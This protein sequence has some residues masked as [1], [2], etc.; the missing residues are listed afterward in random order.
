MFKAMVF[1][2]VAGTGA[3]AYFLARSIALVLSA[4]LKGLS[5][6]E[7]TARQF[8]QLICRALNYPFPFLPK[9]SLDPTNIINKALDVILNDVFGN[10][11][12][13][14]SSLNDSNYKQ[15]WTPF[16]RRNLLQ[17]FAEEALGRLVTRAEQPIAPRDYRR[18][19][20]MYI[21]RVKT[22]WNFQQTFESWQYTIDKGMVYLDIAVTVF[23]T[24]VA[25]FAAIFFPASTLVVAGAITTRELQFSFV[26]FTSD[27]ARLLASLGIQV[28]LLATYH[29]MTYDLMDTEDIG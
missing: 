25:T 23:V 22:G 18:R 4:A 12:N 26:R 1:L 2:M 7:G 10:M 19:V 5:F 14:A 24:V 21:S 9:E 29:L 17:C 8:L 16:T 3:I 13:W 6:S 11:L 15:I 27:F 28:V 20:G